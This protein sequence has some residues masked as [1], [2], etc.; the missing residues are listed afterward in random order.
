MWIRNHSAFHGI[1][2]DDIEH[3]IE[4]YVVFRRFYDG[5]FEKPRRNKLR[6]TVNG[7]PYFMSRCSREYLHNYM[8][9]K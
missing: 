1:V 9:V 4:D 2:I 8:E 3:G 7:E 6:Y 5:K